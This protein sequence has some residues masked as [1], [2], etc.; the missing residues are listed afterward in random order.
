MS[1][2]THAFGFS[3]EAQ[4]MSDTINQAIVDGHR[5]RWYAFALED[6][7]SD[8][9]PYDTRRDAVRHHHNRHQQFMFIKIPWDQCTPR[10]A[11]VNIRLYRQLKALGQHPDDLDSADDQIMTDN[12]REAYP[13]LD[14]RRALVANRTDNTG[15]RR[16][17]GGLILP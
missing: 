7:T 3:P 13:A 4:R 15:E 1:A 12:R 16:S 9:V 11:E 8:K 5:N 17:P 14:G 6:C 2:E 10:A